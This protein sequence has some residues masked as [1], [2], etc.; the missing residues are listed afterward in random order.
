MEK[1]LKASSLPICY[2][3]T[4]GFPVELL[5]SGDC[6]IKKGKEDIRNANDQ[7]STRKRDASRLCSVG[8]SVKSGG[9]GHVQGWV[10]SCCLRAMRQTF[11]ISPLSHIGLPASQSRLLREVSQLCPLDT[12]HV[13]TCR[14]YL[15]QSV[16]AS[17]T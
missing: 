5:V 4:S 1:G 17:A 14:H 9:M 3:G 10:M 7:E 12:G 16:A 11:C 13:L 2:F 8:F 6:K 15:V